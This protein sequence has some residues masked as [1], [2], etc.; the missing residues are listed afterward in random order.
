MGS[1]ADWSNRMARNTPPRSS[2]DHPATYRIRVRGRLDL[3]WSDWF[4][5]MR[6][7]VAGQENGLPVT[8]LSGIVRDQSALHGLLNRIRDLDLALL[9]LE[10]LTP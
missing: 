8:T 1:G 7:E 4:D 9:T 10:R 6:I 2:G 5:D 3:G